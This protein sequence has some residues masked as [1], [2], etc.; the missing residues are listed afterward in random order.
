MLLALASQASVS[1]SLAPTVKLS[2]FPMHAA[3]RLVLVLPIIKVL[4]LHACGFFHHFFSLLTSASAAAAA[5]AAAVAQGVHR[6]S[7]IKS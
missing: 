6:E 7:G 3:S 1:F 5:A 2:H 4:L